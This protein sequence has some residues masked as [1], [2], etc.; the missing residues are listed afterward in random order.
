MPSPKIGVCYRRP[1]V[2]ASRKGG[3]ILTHL[4]K[5]VAAEAVFFCGEVHRRLQPPFP[6]TFSRALLR[7][8]QGRVCT[9][10]TPSL[11]LSIVGDGQLRQTLSRRWT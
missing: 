3:T 2:A 1:P 11:Q 6:K 9:G 10:W 4:P 7:K 5:D 8:M